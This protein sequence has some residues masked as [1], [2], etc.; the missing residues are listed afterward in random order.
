LVWDIVKHPPV[1]RL[2]ERALNPLVGKSIVVYARKP[3]GASLPAA[4][5]AP[6]AQ[7]HARG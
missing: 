5:P 7:A 2:A 6:S 3:L 1:T 4:V